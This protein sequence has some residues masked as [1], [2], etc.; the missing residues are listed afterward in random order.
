MIIITTAGRNQY[1]AK[2][3]DMDGTPF[4][5]FR[6]K[7]AEAT[8]ALSAWRMGVAGEPANSVR[9]ELVA[10]V[11]AEWPFV[12]WVEWFDHNGNWMDANPSA[13]WLSRFVTDQA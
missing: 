4:A 9:F 3:R 12:Q 6:A 2:L 13:D 7:D 8:K 5:R 1:T 11:E 10:A